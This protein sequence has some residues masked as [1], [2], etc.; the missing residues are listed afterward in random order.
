M[1]RSNPPGGPHASP[2]D[3]LGLPESRDLTDDDV[4]SAWRRIAAV[5]HPDRPGG[6]DPAR[7]AAASAAYTSL[8]TRTGRGEA[9]AG[10]PRAAAPPVSPPRV[11]PPPV[12]PPRGP[13]ARDLA[14]AVADAPRYPAR[15]AG[16]LARAV[17][18]VVR[19]RPAMLAARLLIV[20]AVGV[21]SAAL[22]GSA[23]ATPALITGALTWFALTAR[24]D[25]APPP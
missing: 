25:L 10:M 4:R 24:H 2:F 17:T 21:L 20:V 5:T 1:T 16:L 6:G 11:S 13:A 12:S 8:R 23:P 18:R 9:L 7:F 3:V 19:G 22:V 14:P 15:P